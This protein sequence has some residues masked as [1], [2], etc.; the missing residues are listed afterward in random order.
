MGRFLPVENGVARK[1]YILM[2][3]EPL[4]QYIHMMRNP[5]S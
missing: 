2:T 3:M 1:E 4:R 5:K